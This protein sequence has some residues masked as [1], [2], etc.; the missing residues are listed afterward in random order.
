MIKPYFDDWNTCLY[1]HN[2][3]EV[4]KMM[5]DKTVDLVLTDPPYGI[6]YVSGHRKEKLKPIAND[7]VLFMDV[8]TWWRVVKEGGSLWSFYGQQKQLMDDRIK[9]RIIWVKPNWTAGDLKGNFG[10]QYECIAFMP[11]GKFELRG[12]R[13][14]NVWN[15]GK[16]NNAKAGGHPTEKPVELLKRIIEACTDKGD[17]VFDPFAGSGSTLIACKM[18]GRRFIGCELD[19][20]HCD[21]LINGSNILQGG[22]GI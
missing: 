18:T 3:L 19:K 9:N 13:Y 7:D 20:G 22:F 10:Y 1:N 14:S 4:V 17:L 11:K 8:D 15:F 21:K 12:Y 16:P 5:G 6:D 2:C